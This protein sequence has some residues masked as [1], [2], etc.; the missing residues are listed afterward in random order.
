MILGAAKAHFRK[1]RWAVIPMPVRCWIPDSR[2]AMMDEADA[3]ANAPPR[4]T[5]FGDFRLTRPGGE[6]IV[7]S[8]KRAQALLAIRCLDPGVA[9]ARDRLCELLWRG[10]LS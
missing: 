9:V 7:I 8:G 10:R 1:Q 4:A 6:E 3:I 5:L 2:G